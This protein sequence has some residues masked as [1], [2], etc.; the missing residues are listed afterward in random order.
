M[1]DR[2]R[3]KLEKYFRR[4]IPDEREKTWQQN[5]AISLKRTKTVP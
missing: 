5:G 1:W 3:T 2:V 4:R